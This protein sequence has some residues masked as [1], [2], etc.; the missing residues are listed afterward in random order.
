MADST[1]YADPDQTR[2]FL[3][4]DDAAPPPGG[5]VLW[6]LTGSRLEV[7][8]EGIALYEITEEEAKERTR[9]LLTGY[10]RQAT[11]VL[12]GLGAMMRQA[13]EA[14]PGP[15]EPVPAQANLAQTLGLTE[16]ELKNDPEAV[17]EGL[18]HIGAGLSQSL[19]DLLS[20]DPA[21]AEATRERVRA[22]AEAVGVDPDEAD[23]NVDELSSK[24]REAFLNPEVEAQIRDATR[25][26]EEATADLK[27]PSGEE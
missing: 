13:A 19:A 3:V 11:G 20:D 9:D 23:T 17:M 27:R 7:D 18:R 16:E 8:P 26:L 15:P 12:A 21:S 24:L 10:A 22:L 6:S 5:L 25:K 1:L 4:P 2:F 14:E